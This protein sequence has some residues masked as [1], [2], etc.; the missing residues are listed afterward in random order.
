MSS[1]TSGPNTQQSSS[2]G[3]WWRDLLGG[4]SSLLLL[5]GV[6]LYGVLGLIYARFYEPLGVDPADVGLGY[7]SVLTHAASI[8]GVALAFVGIAPLLLIPAAILLLL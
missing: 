4:L 6:L 1:D 7:A 5:F 3:A 8:T 2:D